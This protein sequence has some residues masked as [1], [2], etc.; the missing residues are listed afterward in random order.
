MLQ[1]ELRSFSN[2]GHSLANGECCDEAT[3]QPTLCIGEC[4]NAFVFCWKNYN[5]MSTSIAANNCISRGS[6]SVYYN[7]DYIN[8]PIGS[9]HSNAVTH[10]NPITMTG[11]IWP[12]SLNCFEYIYPA[13]MQYK[14]W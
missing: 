9:L 2:P 4:D 14:S 5:S 11:D 10:R 6:T 8:F 13:V 7:R 3:T 12:V 1:L